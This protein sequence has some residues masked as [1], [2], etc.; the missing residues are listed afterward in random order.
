MT[1]LSN[2]EL[3]A[4]LA[5]IQVGPWSK[6]VA[7]ARRAL[8]PVADLHF[9]WDAR[10]LSLDKVILS[11][12]NKRKSAQLQKVLRPHYKGKPIKSMDEIETRE[13]FDDALT[14]PQLYELA[15]QTGY[16]PEDSVKDSARSFATDF[17]WSVPARAFVQSYDYIVVPMLAARFGISGFPATRP[18]QTNPHST[19]RFAGF[20][21]HLRAFYS[22][23]Q[24]EVWLG[25]LDDYVVKD[26]EQDLLWEYL[27]GR[28]TTPPKR[29]PALLTGCQR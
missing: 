4:R 7:K 28:R 26:N 10:L 21:A 23:D 20:L 18:P 16:L 6:G 24:I 9:D 8:A 29:Y 13:A 3:E 19:I 17:L 14:I 11:A 5:G 22:D 27:R 1:Q 25:F 15:I 12:A 2:Q